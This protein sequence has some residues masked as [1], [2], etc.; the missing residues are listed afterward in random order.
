MIWYIPTELKGPIETVFSCNIT[1]LTRGAP[2]S[3][4]ILGNPLDQIPLYKTCSSAEELTSTR[5]SPLCR[6]TDVCRKP[7]VFI[8]KTTTEVVGERP[9][10]AEEDCIPAPLDALTE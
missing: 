7:Y 10:F 8:C 1:S 3:R 2:G 6:V 5:S 4:C 9:L